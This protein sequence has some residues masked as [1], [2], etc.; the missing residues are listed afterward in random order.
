[1]SSNE[2]I[3]SLNIPQLVAT[4]EMI[5]EKLIN[6]QQHMQE[7]DAF[8]RSA[9]INCS[10]KTVLDTDYRPSGFRGY[11]EFFLNT[12]SFEHG[13]KAIDEKAWRFLFE[14]S[15]AYGMMSRDRRNQWCTILSNWGFPELSVEAV[16]G[17]FS[18]LYDNRQ[19][20]REEGIIKLFRSLSWN[21]KSNL[22]FKFGKKL[23]LTAVTSMR[24][25]SSYSKRTDQLDD[26]IRMFCWFDAKPEPE[27]SQGFSQI[28][29]NHL[30]KQE[31]EYDMEYFKVK[32]F[33]NGNA[34]IIFKNPELVASLNDVIVKHFPG[35]LA[36]E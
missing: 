5:K 4:R 12:E 13:I 30:T 24:Q 9:G 14:K 2:L 7:V 23:V 32:L 31:Y 10:L 3:T 36:A 6:L 27:Y 33:K 20:M 11:K 35:A 29:L 21:Y 18:E 26:L 8:I 15:G 28:M 25:Y 34:H 16:K 17:T 1:M 22:P 19:A